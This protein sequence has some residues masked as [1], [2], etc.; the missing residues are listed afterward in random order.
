MATTWSLH[1]STPYQTIL[2]TKFADWV[3][4]EVDVVN[5]GDSPGRSWKSDPLLSKDSTL[6]PGDYKSANTSTLKADRGHQAPLASIAA[7]FLNVLA[8]E[9]RDTT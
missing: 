3:T 9:R 6:E 2:A 4:Y 5:F 1:T 8:V 7:K